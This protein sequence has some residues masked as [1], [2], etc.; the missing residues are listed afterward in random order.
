MTSTVPIVWL[1]PNGTQRCTCGWARR[2]GKP[3]SDTIGAREAAIH[4]DLLVAEAHAEYCPLHI[5]ALHDRLDELPDILGTHMPGKV[6][7]LLHRLVQMPVAHTRPV[8]WQWL[9]D[10]D[11][12]LDAC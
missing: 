8:I 12:D 3:K 6:M 9:T 2:P 7:A 1:D 10:L 11:N 5:Q 4:E